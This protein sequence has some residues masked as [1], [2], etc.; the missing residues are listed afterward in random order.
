MRLTTDLQLGV[1]ISNPIAGIEVSGGVNPI[2]RV[3][4]TTKPVVTRQGAY[5]SWNSRNEG[6][7]ETDF[8]NNRGRGEGGFA[9]FNA[10]REGVIGEPVV[11]ITG[12]NRMGIGT[13]SPLATLDVNGGVR[14]GGTGEVSQC[15]MGR[16]AG[17]GTQRYNY[18]T[19][20]M[21]Y[22]NGSGWVSLAQAAQ[23]PVIPAGTI[24]GLYN[25]TSGPYIPCGGTFCPAGWQFR[26]REV[27]VPDPFSFGSEIK[28]KKATDQFCVKL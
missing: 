1:G 3:A 9:F 18:S 26:T 17:E 22:C 11:V 15:G 10:T 6:L 5:L 24:C 7:G 21:E 28:V 13:K 2:L 12:Q 14:A 19:H 16:E 25:V 4:G 20:Q 8:I 27:L 23:V